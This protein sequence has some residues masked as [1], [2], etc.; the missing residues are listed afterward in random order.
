MK[1]FAL[2]LL[3]VWPLAVEAQIVI[4]GNENKIDLDLGKPTAVFDA[5]ADSISIIDFSRFPPRVRHLTGI[6]NS[7]LGPPSNIAITPDG[8]VALIASS[9]KLDRAAAEGYVPDTLI[10]VLDLASRPPRVV[11]KVHA[12]RQPSGMS[13]TPDGRRALVANRADGTVTVLSISGTQVKPVQTV[14]VAAPEDSVADVAI[15]PDGKLA[16]VSV[17][18]RHQLRVLAL[19]GANVKATDRKLSVCGQPYRTVIT[20]DGQLALTAG[21]G[22]GAPDADALTVVDL[23]ARPI[24]TVDYVTIG[25]GPESIEVSPDGKLVAAVLMNGSSAP[26]GDPRRTPNGLLVLLARRGKTYTPV[27]RVAVGRVPEG[28]A[29]TSD[30]KYLLVQ[31][32]PAREIWVLRVSDE[33]VEDTGQRIKT[34]GFPSSL[35]AAL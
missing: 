27:Q 9:I 21:A 12:G 20:A 33:S 8:K 17:Q 28:V 29:F 14:Q 25:S 26:A 11:A 23:A 30:G 19:D 35:R 15:S 34:P 7:V 2:L 10:H 16:L 5:Q 6:A 3:I 18:E 4:S 31:C 22:Q 1:R 13:I 24:R 32:H